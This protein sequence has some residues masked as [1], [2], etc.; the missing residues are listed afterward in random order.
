MSFNLFAL[1]HVDRRHC[2]GEEVLQRNFEV[3]QRIGNLCDLIQTG[4]GSGVSG[5]FLERL[6]PMR[7][8]HE[9]WAGGERERWEERARERGACHRTNSGCGRGGRVQS[10]RGGAQRTTRGCGRWGGVQSARGAGCV[11]CAS[12]SP[13]ASATSATSLKLFTHRS[14]QLPFFCLKFSWSRDQIGTT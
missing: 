9:D 2:K 3:P 7:R 14:I 8:M 12:R 1:V 11:S 6:G 13:S 4:G 10:A 5:D